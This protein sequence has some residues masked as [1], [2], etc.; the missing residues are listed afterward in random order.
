[1]VHLKSSDA[2]GSPAGS[3]GRKLHVV[4]SMHLKDYTGGRNEIDIP[5]AESV[6]VLIG[7]L[8]IL[9]PGISSRI[10][11]DQGGVRRHVNIFVDG[12][13]IRRGAG[14]RTSLSDALE[15]VILPSVAGG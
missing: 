13:E 4:L 6:G 10:L 12:E 15:V 8:D 2:R 7:D 3:G 5:A 14:I 9:F 11:D 1:M